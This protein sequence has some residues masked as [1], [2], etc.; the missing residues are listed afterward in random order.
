MAQ[1]HGQIECLKK[2]KFELSSC[3]IHRFKSIKE[4]NEFLYNFQDEKEAIINTQKEIL[5]TEIKDLNLRLKENRDKCER[6]KSKTLNYS[7]FLGPLLV[8]S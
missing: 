3:G 1:I 2:L 6:T 8:S 5:I 7:P 4:I